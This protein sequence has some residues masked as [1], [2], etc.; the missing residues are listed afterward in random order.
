M[1]LPRGLMAAVRIG[2]FSGQR[3]TESK[4][5][6]SAR[7]HAGGQITIAAIADDEHDGGVA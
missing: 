2:G 3:I 6:G 1:S 7:E 5:P 4:G